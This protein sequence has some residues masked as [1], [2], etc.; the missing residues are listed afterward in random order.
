M[1]LGMSAGHKSLSTQW[2]INYQGASTVD[3][4]GF[5]TENFLFSHFD[6]YITR[7]ITKSDNKDHAVRL[8]VD[9]EQV[10]KKT[11]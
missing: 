2:P 11:Q 8:Q 6:E 7:Y 1:K 10:R 5:L 3:L 4:L 9:H